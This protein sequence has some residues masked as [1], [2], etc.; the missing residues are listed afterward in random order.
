MFML[1]AGGQHRSVIFIFEN[2]K[3]AGAEGNDSTKLNFHLM[4]PSPPSPCYCF[5]QHNMKIEISVNID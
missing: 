2:L 4:F 5:M 3:S 1:L